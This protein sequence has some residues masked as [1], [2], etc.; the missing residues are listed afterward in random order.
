MPRRSARIHQALQLA[1]SLSENDIPK[2]AVTEDKP[3]AKKARI[4][5]TRNIGKVAK[6]SPYCL[7]RTLE[8]KQYEK[9]EEIN[10]VIG[11]DE[12][13][14]GPLCGPVVAAA[15][16][17][18]K[19]V[20]SLSGIIDS[21]KITKE[22]DREALYEQLVKIKGIQYAVAVIDAKRVDEINILRATLEGM[23]SAAMALINPKDLT[24]RLL[25][26]ACAKEEGC[27]IVSSSEEL[28]S[29][30]SNSKKN[31]VYESSRNYFSLID[32]NKVPEEMPCEADAIVKG[33]SKEFIIAAASILAK[34]TRDRL[35]HEY[36]EIYPEF[37]LAQHKGYPTAAHIAV[38]SS[39]GI[40]PIHR[41]TFA[42][43]KYMDLDGTC[44]TKSKKSMRKKRI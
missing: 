36:D 42:P 25:S 7:P 10:S 23:R 37:N 27:Y 41:R 20:P 17:Y 29:S 24:I 30:S 12:A 40:T 1:S 22:A 13:G 6:R 15:V 28:L 34:V 14:R 32:G 11:I 19:D 9:N 31:I 3:K 38:I 44:K 35:M 33:D 5:K 26:K 18:P 16:I 4:E 39:N 2:S 43:L 21:K 8:F